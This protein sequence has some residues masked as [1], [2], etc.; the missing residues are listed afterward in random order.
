MF[1]ATASISTSESLAVSTFIEGTTSGIA[2]VHGVTTS[3][4]NS[5]SSL[6][7]SD[8]GAQMQAAGYNR[9]LCQYSSTTP[10]AVASF[11][12]RNFSINFDNSNSVIAMMYKQE[13]SVVAET[14]TPAQAQTLQAKNINVFVNYVN[15]T[16]IVQY[17]VMSSGQFFDVIQ[18]T[19]WLQ[20]AIQTNV[21]NALYT[22]PTKVPQTDSGVNTITNAI[23]S[24]CGQGVTNGTI[25]GG[26]WNGPAFGSLVTGQYLK[27]GYYIY[28]QPLAQQSE[29][30][31]AE[32][33]CPP[34][35]VAV[36]L[37][38]AIATVD[39]LVQVNQ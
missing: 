20:N 15:N 25:A 8:I 19:D 9:S 22:S 26:T 23:S 24:A 29:A 14:L 6:S 37:A 18:D 5:L 33:I 10:H 38:G 4:T 2:R 21:Y 27:A 35:Q 12:G 1:S 36:K 31:R 32:R 3:D 28:A 17:G 39:V 13:P 34:I 11:F 30:Q 7:S 16:A